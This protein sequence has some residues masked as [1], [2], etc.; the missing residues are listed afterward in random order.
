MKVQKTKIAALEKCYAVAPLLWHGAPH[1]LVSAERQGPCYL[2][3]ENGAIADTVWNGPG[4]VMTMLQV[5]GRDG[6]FLATNLFFSP[7]ESAAAKI[8]LAQQ[9]AGGRWGTRTLLELPFVH[10]FGIL[11]RG[12]V[13]YIIACTL[14]SAHRF[15]ND[16]SAPG[17]VLAAVL[18]D[19]LDAFGT[20]PGKKPLVLDVVRDGMLKNH[21]YVPRRED[22]MDTCLVSCD[23]GVY[24]FVPPA[25]PGAPWEVTHLCPDAASDAVL[26]DLDGDGSEEL[27]TISPFHGNQISIYRKTAAGY[28]EKAYHY[29]TAYFAHSIYGGTLLGRPVAVIGHR[30][31]ARDLLAFTW[32]AAG[33]FAAEVL[34]HGCG[35]ANI[36]KFLRGGQE[37]LLSANRESDEVALYTF[38]E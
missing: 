8:V 34:D 35:S 24:R 3:D 29:D 27:I 5:P 20:D 15:E 14:K 28:T 1:Y 37:V 30:E 25:A 9:D 13:K 2:F 23:S 10:R 26:V 11:E 19:D 16:W 7:N 18:P 21:G 31:G 12:G 36:C 22:G 33:C 4:G 17:K 32:D 6:V 38:A